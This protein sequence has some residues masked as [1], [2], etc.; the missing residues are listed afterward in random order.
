MTRLRRFRGALSYANV[1]ATVAVFLALGGVAG[2]AIKP[3]L[4]RRGTVTGRHVA[5]G[6][7]HMSDLAPSVRKK[8]ASAV[9]PNGVYSGQ[10]TDGSLSITAI[11]VRGGIGEMTATGDCPFAAQMGR[12]A[13][14]SPPGGFTFFGDGAE[15]AVVQVDTRD[16]PVVRSV[17]VGEGATQKT[18]PGPVELILRE[19]SQTAGATRLHGSLRPPR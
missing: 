10:A 5:R 8:I 2:A 13:M 18:C 11:F 1:M 16:G 17:T 6:A 14:D 3:L 12:L 19:G 15:N 9:I 7:I 4:D